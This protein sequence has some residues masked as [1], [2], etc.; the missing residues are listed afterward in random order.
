MALKLT[1]SLR[2][3]HQPCKLVDEQI[4]HEAEENKISEFASR[5]KHLR[6]TFRGQQL[7][8]K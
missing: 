7:Q 8:S 6:Q 4:A 3:T 2:K 5:K 1:L